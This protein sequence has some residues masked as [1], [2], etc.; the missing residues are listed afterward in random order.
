MLKKI[1]KYLIAIALLTIIALV[2][3]ETLVMPFYV[4]QGKSRELIDVTSLDVK[5]ALIMIRTSGFRGVVSDTIYTDQVAPNTVLDQFPKPGSIVKKKRTVRLKIS[6]SEKMVKVPFLVGQSQRSAE[7]LLK[8]LGLRMGAVTLDYSQIYPEGVIIDQIPDSMQSIP[9]GYNV[10]VIIS[11]G[12]SP[13]EILVPSLFGLSKDAA[14]VELENAGLKIGKIHYKQNE[15]LIPYTVLDQSI[16][17][18]TILEEAQL[19]DITVSV[20]DLQDI[21]QDVTN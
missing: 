19:I 11:Q 6:Q 7:I 20:L 21:F 13:N 9:K 17:A 10:R 4:R 18:G 16:P 12:R 5:S 1:P 8:K 15:D 3:M 14:D 2:L